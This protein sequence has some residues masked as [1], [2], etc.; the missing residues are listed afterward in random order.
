MKK[1]STYVRCRNLNFLF[2]FMTLLKGHLFV[3]LL[4]SGRSHVEVE[5]S[6]DSIHFIIPIIYK[7][8]MS[9]VSKSCLIVW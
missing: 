1:N 9:N 6:R 2:I 5:W 7:A 8:G 4:C 3:H